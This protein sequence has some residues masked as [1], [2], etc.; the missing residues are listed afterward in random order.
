MLNRINTN[1]IL[2]V[3]RP[4][5]GIYLDMCVLC[6]G[7]IQNQYHI[8]FCIVLWL[9]FYGTLCFGT[10]GECWVC[11]AILD[12]FLLTSFAGVGGGKEAKSLWQ[13]AIYATIWCI[14]LECNSRTFN[15]RFSD[16]LV[17]WDRVRHLASI[18]C[19]AYDLF[20]GISLSNMLK[21]WKAM[22]HR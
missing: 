17:L 15:D 11:P 2:Q 20:R 9:I 14:W 10:F 12:Q 21:D 3:Q 1:D 4:H 18:W 5:K 6:V 13:C 19:I 7:Q 8:C 22:L 16:E